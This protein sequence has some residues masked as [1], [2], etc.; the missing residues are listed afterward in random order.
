MNKSSDQI[1]SAEADAPLW[2]WAELADALGCSAVA[3]GPDVNGISIDTRSANPGDL[4]IALAGDPGM[5]FFTSSPGQRDGHEF[6]AAAADAG[7]AGA[8]VTQRQ[9]MDLPQLEVADTLDGLWALGAAAV[10]RHQGLRFA[11]TG[12][13]G[14]TTCKAFLA[15]AL[16]VTAEPG[17]MNN[18]WG[19]PVCLART[20]ASAP[21][22][23]YEVGTNQPGEIEPL[24]RLVAP[25]VAVLLNVHPAHL[26][27]FAS[28]DA[29]HEEKLSISNSL[30]SKSN[31]VCE[32]SVALAAGLTEQVLTFGDESGAT[33]RVRELVGDRVVFETPDGKLSA[34]VPGGG[35]HRALTLAA[36]VASLYCAGEDPQKAADLPASLVP[37]GRGNELLVTTV[38]GGHW[39]LLD[40]SYNANPASMGAALDTLAAATGPRY[41]ILGEMLELGEQSHDYHL[42]LA[43]HCAQ[44]TGVYCVGDACRALYDGLPEH[45]RLGYSE[46]A[47]DIDLEAL[48]RGL[49]ESGRVL[50]KGS[51]RVFWQGDFLARLTAALGDK[52]GEK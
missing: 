17:S 5:R 42:A 2:R 4:F 36:V 11:I 28:L 47:A 7:V 16:G 14:K 49:P 43:S 45:Q 30:E 51:N 29:L 40:D 19:V 13:S 33:V 15:S 25:Q 20:P 10:T 35:Q 12:S 31:F 9:H 44:L 26:G 1:R 32:Y 24:A 46:R 22:A 34:R 18:F 39:V 6:V 3:G 52:L 21:F 50:V 41:A 27:N 38:A 48:M 37:K 8:V 23:V